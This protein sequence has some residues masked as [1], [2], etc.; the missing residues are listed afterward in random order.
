M[1]VLRVYVDDFNSS[2]NGL[3]LLWPSGR[4]MSTIAGEAKQAGIE[5]LLATALVAKQS[6]MRNGIRVAVESGEYSAQHQR[7]HP[8]TAQSSVLGLQSQGHGFPDN[9]VSFHQAI[10]L[11]VCRNHATM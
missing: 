4:F 10:P 8:P 11:W 9:A 3:Y 2:T 7:G 6:F 5:F 1:I